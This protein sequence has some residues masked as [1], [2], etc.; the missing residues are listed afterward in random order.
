M[1]QEFV[2]IDDAAFLLGVSSRTVRNWIH[3]GE[4]RAYLVGPRLIRIDY[5]DIRLLVKPI[6]S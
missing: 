5:E 1:M 6:K 4:L 3:S 2:S